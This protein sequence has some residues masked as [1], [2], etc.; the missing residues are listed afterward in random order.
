MSMSCA[1]IQQITILS[2]GVIIPKYRYLDLQVCEDMAF[3]ELGQVEYYSN[4]CF[5]QTKHPLFEHFSI[6][7]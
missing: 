2:Q 4:R 5:S 1:E 7:I 6:L 3:R